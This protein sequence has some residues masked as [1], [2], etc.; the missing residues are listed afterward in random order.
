MR[1]VA[2]EFTAELCE[3]S[4]VPPAPFER[5]R[6]GRAS[7]KPTSTPPRPRVGNACAVVVDDGD[8]EH[9][10]ASTI[11]RIDS[12]GS[13]QVLREGAIA[14]DR[15]LARAAQLVLFV[16]S[17]NTCRSPMAEG[18]AKKLWAD[19][20]GIQID[21]LVEH[22]ILVVSAGTAAMPGMP[23]SENAIAAAA[24]IGID[25]SAHRSRPLEPALV[26]RAHEIYCLTGSH[27]FAAIALLE[28]AG[29][30]FEEDA[31]LPCLLAIDRD[32]GDPFGGDLETY[33]AV[34]DEI[35]DAMPSAPKP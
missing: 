2:H 9:R 20:L 14:R 35:R 18:I 1:V 3:R 24:E 6:Q 30:P 11:V 34:R 17:G 26:A 13:I 4:G 16:C 32:I 29:G 19:E 27:Q 7:R 5:E 23:A 10:V 28:D 31:E 21:E 33:R 22:G 15:V 25:I 12:A 8:S